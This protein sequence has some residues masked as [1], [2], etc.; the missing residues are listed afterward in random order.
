[1]NKKTTKQ[2]DIEI[3]QTKDGAIELS[4]DANKETILAN[5]NQIANLFGVQKAAISKHF[6][7]IFAS[8]ELIKK[9]TVSK[10]ETVQI[11]GGRTIKRS[12]EV[13]NLDAI[14]AV[15][16]RVNSKNATQFRIWAT[17]VLKEYL[18][19]GYVINNKQIANN[20]DNFLKA[21]DSI[22]KLSK[23]KELIGSAE[24]L[25]LVEAF[26]STWL[27]LDV[28]D[29]SNLPK[30]GSGEKGVSFAAEEL[31]KSIGMLKTE[32]VKKGEAT[33][34]FAQ[35]KSK[36]SFIGIVGNVFQ[37]FGGKEL[38]PTVSEKAAHLL[39]FVVKNHVF[40]DGNKRSGAFSFVWFLQKAG[41]LDKESMTPTA[42]TSLTLLIA[43][44]DPKEREN[45]IGLI[46]LLL[47]K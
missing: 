18:V 30:K 22:K 26:A 20:Y 13:Y 44:S 11:E 2:K 34:L 42:L 7:N 28:Y 12:I 45:I 23:N 38:Y 3:Y 1:V 15:G 41:M 25:N 14:I 17:K 37:T 16:Y 5:I 36:D 24:A 9:A 21:V 39:Y 32:L 10:M 27:S 19:K 29:K 43:E 35:E 8:G 40:N 47:K 6:K 4:V 31:K 33:E 46:L